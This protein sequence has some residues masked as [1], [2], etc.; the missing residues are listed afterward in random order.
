MEVSLRI[1]GTPGEAR[2]LPRRPDLL[3]LRQ[4]LALA[5]EDGLVWLL[6]RLDPNPP[7]PQ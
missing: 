1:D 4:M 5:L 6:A 2:R 3:P 7:L